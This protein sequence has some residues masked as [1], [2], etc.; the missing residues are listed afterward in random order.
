MKQFIEVFG[1]FT[2]GDTIILIAA[3][4]FLIS[5]SIKGYKVIVKY[6]DSFQEKNYTLKKIVQAVD[7]LT[8]DQKKLTN[9]ILELKEAQEEI[10][11]RQEAIDRDNKEQALNNTRDRLLQSYNYYTGS[12]NPLRAWSALEKEAFDK[13]FS[14]YENLGGNGYMHS[15]VQPAMAALEVISMTESERLSDLMKSRIG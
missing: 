11:I 5:M 3:I 4:C 12:R 7:N 14:D 10:A 8:L 9:S 15:I 13:L 6:H 2:I 1:D